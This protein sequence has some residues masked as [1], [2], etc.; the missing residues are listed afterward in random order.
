MIK[1]V[2]PGKKEFTAICGKCGCEFTYELSDLICR[3]YVP[4]P[5]CHDEYY[6]PYQ[7]QIFN[8][9]SDT[10]LSSTLKRDLYTDNYEETT[11]TIHGHQ[12]SLCND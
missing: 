10:T 4:C 7:G 12:V 5:E 1:I 11:G 8:G 9:Y 6:H 2:K 3:S